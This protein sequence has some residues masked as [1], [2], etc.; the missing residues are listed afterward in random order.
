MEWTDEQLDKLSQ[1]E[2]Q[3]L[4]DNLRTTLRARRISSAEAERNSLR[5][6]SRLKPAATR[7]SAPAHKALDRQVA[8]ALG[9]VA[10]RVARRF[11]VSG[12]TARLRSY[13][14][15]GFRPEALT[16]RE[17]D[18]KVGGSVKAGSMAI[19]RFISYRQADT[20][21]SLSFVLPKG[22]PVA[23]GRYLFAATGNVLP[24][25]TPIDDIV[26]GDVS[27]GVMAGH[28][29]QMRV[30]PVEDLSHGERLFID[31]IAALAPQRPVR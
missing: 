11:D 28:R 8:R 27:L 25:G 13:G 30:M 16:D 4:L 29:L 18:A 7:R 9:D 14:T 26:P 21:I 31:K 23:E 20:M 24:E 2:L 19:E 22:R 3:Q 10:D 5:I 15:D 17:G 12:E 1:A 6:E